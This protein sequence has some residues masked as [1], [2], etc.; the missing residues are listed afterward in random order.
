M[1]NR[2]VRDNL[3]HRHEVVRCATGGC[4]GPV[5]VTPKPRRFSNVP[6]RARAVRATSAAFGATPRWASFPEMLVPGCVARG[7]RG[8]S[9]ERLGDSAASSAQAGGLA[10]AVVD[11]MKLPL[12]GDFCRACTT[13]RCRRRR[14]VGADAAGR[15]AC[16]SGMPAGVRHVAGTA[17][18]GPGDGRA[19][20]RGRCPG[21]AS[22][23]RVNDD[24][25]QPGPAWKTGRFW[26]PLG[27][28]RRRRPASERAR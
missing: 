14:R 7:V 9:N 21:P 27:G 23:A 22:D 11:Q 26:R 12:R 15:C 5:Q 2:P 1:R 24:M 6:A 19:V 13:C 20:S 25:P 16:R 17:R 4:P 18:P 3:E 10:A 8:V 28:M